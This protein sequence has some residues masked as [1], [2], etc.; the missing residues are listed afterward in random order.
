MYNEVLIIV[1]V[2]LAM[3]FLWFLGKREEELALSF[4]TQKYDKKKDYEIKNNIQN[5]LQNKENNEEFAN[6][7]N[8]HKIDN[9]LKI[10]GIGPKINNLLHQNNINNFEKLSKTK[11]ED[12]QEI[13]KKQG[14]TYPMANPKSWI[15]QAQLANQ[16]KWEELE[17]YKN[18]LYYS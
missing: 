6:I 10:Q 1:L 17:E 11:I 5:Q 2:S 13:L 4:V 8:N 18:Y 12:L 9:F 3:L 15:F 16:E 7:I 14:G